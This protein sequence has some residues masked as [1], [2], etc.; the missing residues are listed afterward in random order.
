MS[1]LFPLSTFAISWIYLNQFVFSSRSSL[2]NYLIVPLTSICSFNFHSAQSPLPRFRGQL[3]LRQSKSYIWRSILMVLSW[4]TL[5]LQKL[6]FW[7]TRADSYMRC[8]FTWAPELM[9]TSVLFGIA[10]DLRSLLS[11]RGG[12]QWRTGREPDTNQR[13]GAWHTWAIELTLTSSDLCSADKRC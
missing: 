7:C 12:S 10:L 1:N 5:F 11:C 9:C 6:T 13:L 8:A 4:H 3:R 2:H